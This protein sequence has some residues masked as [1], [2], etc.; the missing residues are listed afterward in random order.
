R[1]GWRVAGKRPMTRFTD[2]QDREAADAEFR[3]WQER[4]D[5]ETAR[6]TVEEC[7][8]IAKRSKGGDLYDPPLKTDTPGKR[9]DLQ[10]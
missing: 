1:Q 8:E 9:E 3:Q 10:D 4:K 2:H 5:R 7:A 6:L